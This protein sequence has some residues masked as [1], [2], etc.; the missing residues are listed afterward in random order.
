MFKK[1]TISMLVFILLA[2]GMGGMF[3]PVQ[4]ALA[5]APAASA[6]TLSEVEIHSLLYM[7]EEE[8][9]ARDVYAVLYEV[10]GAQIFS[11]I[12]ASEQTH[13][14]QMGV[15]LERYG[16]ED[17]ALAPG[18]F[19]D[20]YIQGLY[21]ML[22]PMGMVSLEGAYRVGAIIEEV[23]ILDFLHFLE[24]EDVDNRDIRQV[25][26]SL[27]NASENHLRG[28]VTCLLSIG[29]V[30]EPGYLTPEQ[31]AAILAEETGGV[32]NTKGH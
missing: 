11:N 1:V 28:F 4:G 29:V 31:Y 22:I 3:K 21:D 12:M 6:A 15:L 25:Y 13:F 14:D 26:T 20:D 5:Q 10:Y 23:D 30:Y 9:L 7:R 27:M 19:T 18:V 8:K 17:P 2:A 16:L 32:G 24:D